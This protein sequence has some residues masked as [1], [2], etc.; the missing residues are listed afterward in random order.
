MSSFMDRIRQPV[1]VSPSGKT[2]NLQF[3]DVERT[4]SKKASVH[5]LP[6]Q[7][8]ALVKDLGNNAK[9]Y[10]MSV[11]FTGK[12]YDQEADDFEA[13]LSETGKGT[14]KHPRYGD[15]EVLP[16]TWTQ[17]EKFVDGLGRADFK[18]DFIHAPASAKYPLTAV[19]TSSAISAQ[20]STAV[21]ASALSQAAAF[22]TGAAADIARLKANIQAAVGAVT[23]A[24][25]QVM[26]I[27]E[28]IQSEVNATISFIEDNIDALV[29]APAEL[30]ASLNRLAALPANIVTG[31]TS[32]VTCYKEMIENIVD[33]TVESYAQASTGVQNL[34]GYFGGVAVASTIGGSAGSENTSGGLKSRSDAVYAAELLD[35]MTQT[36]TAYLAAVESQITDYQADPDTVA[37]LIDSLSIARASLL[38]RSYDLKIERK[39]KLTSD[40]TPIDLCYELYGDISQI[41]D[42]ISQNQLAG[43]DIILIPSGHEVVYYA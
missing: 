18:I 33:Q 26:A 20:V 34:L 4:G 22:V 41:E 2:Y 32:K 31:I 27:S 43:D 14:L 11:Y 24:F 30:F 23:G 19:A 37:A 7:N 25:A 40:R 13:A 35:E 9:K 29:Q 42:F 38:A 17:T 12:N 8:Y 16:L 39:I 3:D 10:P 5:E 1:Y 15:I 28:E 6:Q 36:V 21:N